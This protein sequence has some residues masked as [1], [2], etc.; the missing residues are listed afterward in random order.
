MI[1]WLIL[2]G[3]T[4]ATLAYLALPFLTRGGDERR[5]DDVA[6]YRDQLAEIER[7]VVAGR[8]APQEAEA[9]RIEVSRRLLQ[10]AEREKR[11]V[12]DTPAV[13]RGRR[14]AAVAFTILALPAIAAAFYYRLG[15]PWE[16]VPKPAVE[17]KAPAGMSLAEM[18]SRV[19]AHVRDNPNDGRSYEVLAPV[20]MRIARFD[21]AIVAWRKTIEILGDTAIREAGLGEALVGKAQG[22]VTAEARAVFDKALAQDAGNV[23]ARY[24]LA[25]AAFQDGKRE[26][27]RRMWTDML[28]GAP[29][30]APW[31]A[32]IRRALAAMDAQDAPKD[33]SKDSAAPGP[34][35][36]DIEAA[37]KMDQGQR[38]DFIRSMVARLADKL[39][40]NGDDPEGWARLV[41]AYGVLGETARAEEATAQ[42]RKALGDNATKLAK[43][44]D[45]LKAAPTAPR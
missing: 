26:D 20:Y 24:Y 35:A 39:Q 14:T 2:L 40:Q 33:E 18:I 5:G 16:A 21:D 31:T 42:A 38:N 27:A 43:F 3:M 1:F 23:P 19:E 36:A 44:E 17:A 41:K 34:G 32:P 11:A 8:I 22:E 6:V 25:L 12:G 37:A 45:A 15:A 7:D 9:S 4:L 30:D 29:P 13:A 28:T 10:A